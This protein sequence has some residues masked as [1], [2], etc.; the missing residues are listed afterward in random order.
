MHPRSSRGTS[1][2]LNIIQIN[3]P[4]KV[5]GPPTP[6]HWPTLTSIISAFVGRIYSFVFKDDTPAVIEYSKE[7]AKQKTNALQ[8]EARATQQNFTR[9]HGGPLQGISRPETVISIVALV[10]SGNGSHHRAVTVTAKPKCVRQLLKEEVGSL[11]EDVYGAHIKAAL[12]SLGRE[13]R[14]DDME[15]VSLGEDMVA[16]SEQAVK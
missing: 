16:W 7:E 6:D 12:E 13:A 4:P 8:I 1:T 15:G 2:H 3:L 10:P 14:V 5:I 9:S 11:A